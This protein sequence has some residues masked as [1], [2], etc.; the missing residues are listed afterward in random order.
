MARPA[1]TRAPDISMNRSDFGGKDRTYA[2]RR[3]SGCSE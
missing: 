1:I 3:R 2:I